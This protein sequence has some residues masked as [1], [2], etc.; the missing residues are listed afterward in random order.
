MDRRGLPCSAFALT[1]KPFLALPKLRAVLC[2]PARRMALAP[3]LLHPNVE[4]HASQSPIAGGTDAKRLAVLRLDCVRTRAEQDRN[5]VISWR[6]ASSLSS[7]TENGS[8]H[9]MQLLVF[10]RAYPVSGRT[11][12]YRVRMLSP[13]RPQSA[14]RVI[15]T[16]WVYK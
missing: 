8:F 6:K 15:S 4:T 3:L 16:A 5:W 13:G 10:E 2:E 14:N 12:F 7:A 9:A 1:C 11:L